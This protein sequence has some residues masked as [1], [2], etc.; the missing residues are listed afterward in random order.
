MLRIVSIALAI[1]GCRLDD[2]PPPAPAEDAEAGTG[3]GE[4]ELPPD[5]DPGTAGEGEGE[6]S[7]AP[8]PAGEGEGEGEGV[9]AGEAVCWRVATKCETAGGCCGQGDVTTQMTR[10]ATGERS[11]AECQAYMDGVPVVAT[12]PLACR[13]AWDD[14]IACA[15]DR[16]DGTGDFDCT[17]RRCCPALDDML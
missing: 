3:E 1:V 8:R 12:F 15:H 2:L 5:P 7:P 11:Q 6:A 16:C 4:G 9:S 13:T 10:C 14:L 17:A